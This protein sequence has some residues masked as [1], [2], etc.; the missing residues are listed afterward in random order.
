MKWLALSLETFESLPDI[1]FSIKKPLFA[2]SIVLK[3]AKRSSVLHATAELR[4]KIPVKSPTYYVVEVTSPK[5]LINKTSS[6]FSFSRIEERD[7]TGRSERVT[8]V[9]GSRLMI[10]KIALDAVREES[11]AKFFDVKNESPVP[12]L[13]HLFVLPAF[14]ATK[15]AHARIYAGY[16]CVGQRIQAIRIERHAQHDDRED[17]VETYVGKIISVPYALKESEWQSLPWAAKTGFEFDWDVSKRTIIA[18]RFHVPIFGQLE[19]RS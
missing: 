17:D 8:T 7:E 19:I 16:I 2:A 13:A 14:Q 12:I 4:A 9:E 18:A 3:Y 5:Q 10:E 1:S 15:D 6:T 11:K